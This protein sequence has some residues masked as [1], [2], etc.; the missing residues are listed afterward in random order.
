AEEIQFEA[1]VDALI[2]PNPA[3]ETISIY[4]NQ[5]ENYQV[6]VMNTMGQVV[7]E[8]EFRDHLDIPIGTM[9]SGIYYLRIQDQKSKVIIVKKVSVL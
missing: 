6:A 3:T 9:E 2:Y 4:M 7:F 8:K 1:T 5:N